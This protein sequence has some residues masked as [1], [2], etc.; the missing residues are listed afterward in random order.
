MQKIQTDKVINVPH[1]KKHKKALKTPSQVIR[2]CLVWCFVLCLFLLSLPFINATFYITDDLKKTANV[3]EAYSKAATQQEID[4]AEKELQ[5]AID[6]L[7]T[8]PQ[9]EESALEPTNAAAIDSAQF[10]WVY[11]VSSD[12][13]TKDLQKLIM[14]AK[15]IDRSTYTDKSVETL[16]KTVTN[17][18]KILGASV[19]ISQTGL[20]L[21]FGGSISEMFRGTSNGTIANSLFAYALGIIPLIC[22]FAASFDKTRHIKHI[23]ALLGSILCLVDIYF[24]IYPFIAIGSVLTIIMY[25]IICVLNIF[26]IYA[27]QQE[28]Y[29]MKH[30]E[31]EAEFTEKH[32]LFVN[33]LINYKSFG[34]RQTENTSSDKS[35]LSKKSKKQHIKDK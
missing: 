13:N 3:Q 34:S 31:L 16:N 17:A 27:K 5:A 21:M 28:D 24:I 12:V 10:D 2:I 18:Q 1:K 11:H 19:T 29:I 9:K 30:P 23:I 32:P 15:D 4:S 33:A 14:Q 8:D 6:G 7:E 25:I 26:S 20:Q 22:F 35:D